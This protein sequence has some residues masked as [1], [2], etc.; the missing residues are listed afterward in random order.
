LLSLLLLLLL[1]SYI[2]YFVFVWSAPPVHDMIFYE[3]W[4][5]GG[6]W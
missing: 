3:N 1:I 5:G 2:M 4:G 6:R